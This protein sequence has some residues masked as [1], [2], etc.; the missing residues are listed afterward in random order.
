MESHNAKKLISDGFSIWYNRPAAVC[1]E[2]VV[3]IGSVSS[4]G[5]AQ[6][7]IWDKKADRIK[8]CGLIQND[9]VSDH[10]SPVICEVRKRVVIAVAAHSSRLLIFNQENKDALTGSLSSPIVLDEA[11]CCYPSFVKDNDE[12]LML[13]YT[14]E[15][16]DP[17]AILETCRSYVM[18]R[19]SDA[20]VTWS[21]PETVLPCHPGESPY[22][23]PPF[24]D[25]HGQLYIYYSKLIRHSSGY[26]DNRNLH[27]KVHNGHEW[28]EDICVSET[29]PGRM[30]QV[31]DAVY[32]G[33]G[34]IRCVWLEADQPWGKSS[35]TEN[36][37][38]VG[39]GVTDISRDGHIVNHLTFPGACGWMI[40]PYAAIIDRTN[41][42]RVILTQRKESTDQLVAWD[43]SAP[44]G[45]DASVAS[46]PGGAGACY[47]FQDTA[48]GLY[49][50]LNYRATCSADYQTD[51]CFMNSHY[52]TQ[53]AHH[54]HTE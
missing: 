32:L 17:C 49:A 33:D 51:I 15:D 54:A 48:G 31:F 52:H 40:Y 18:R 27:M 10:G 24:F 21:A 42:N 22:P 20:G 3:L 11:R 36:W 19:S 14:V 29:S 23:V 47:P 25:E 7:A 30:F 13:F 5:K 28:A 35:Y 45:Q 4:E 43:L 34:I 6:V 37:G 26:Y 46:I 50:H 9:R 41:V 12:N 16:Y 1:I 39:A 38:K 8:S 2:D 53:N 44:R